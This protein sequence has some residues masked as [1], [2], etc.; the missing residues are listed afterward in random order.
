MSKQLV[1]VSTLAFLN[2]NKGKD[3]Y[4]FQSYIY[5]SFTDQDRRP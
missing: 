2:L 1:V 5:C 3:E 4:Q